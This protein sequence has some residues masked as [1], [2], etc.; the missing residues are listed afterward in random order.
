MSYNVKK[1][2]G[3]S[4]Y[5]GGWEYPYKVDGLGD[6]AADKAA[7][8]AFLMEAT[9]PYRDAW[10]PFHDRIKASD[11]SPLI[12]TVATYIANQ[13]G[14]TNA[15]IPSV[16]GGIVTQIMLPENISGGEHF[17]DGGY[18]L[19]GDTVNAA[20]DAIGIAIDRFR[21]LGTGGLPGGAGDL[22]SIL[23][24]PWV[25]AGAAGLGLFWWLKRTKR[26]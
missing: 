11:V 16:A 25:L 26:I 19:N 24:S 13:S 18:R 8:R 9:R 20:G 3:Q 2:L 4:P 17:K 14:S 22:L 7:G 23:T 1:G 5:D 10:L 15:E 6:L 21:S 12:G